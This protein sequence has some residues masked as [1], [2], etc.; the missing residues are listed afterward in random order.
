[1]N[2]SK[3]RRDA[4]NLAVASDGFVSICTTFD[5]Y[6]VNSPG[7][8]KSAI[9]QTNE[10]FDRGAVALKIWKNIGEEVKDPSGVYYLPDNPVFE[11]IYR[12]M[13]SH[14]KTLIAHVADPT[15][16][17]EA[18]NPAVEPLR[19]HS[20]RLETLAGPFGGLDS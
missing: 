11:P 15:T 3:E 14:N 19:A 12:D 7:F 16:V 10:D 9:Q 18:P 8:Q 17:F 2:L 13:A 5:V 1:M 20:H 4:W 6:K